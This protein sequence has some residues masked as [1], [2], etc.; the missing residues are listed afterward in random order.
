MKF[1]R[2]AFPEIV[3]L[4]PLP[5]PPHVVL[6]KTTGWIALTEEQLL[7]FSVPAKIDLPAAAESE[8][9]HGQIIPFKVDGKKGSCQGLRRIAAQRPADIPRF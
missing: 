2:K 8:E 9:G 1:F 3:E 7:A 6:P 5:H 4:G